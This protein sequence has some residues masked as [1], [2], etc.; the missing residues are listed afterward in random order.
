MNALAQPDMVKPLERTQRTSN[1]TDDE[2]FAL[3]REMWRSG[4]MP[5]RGR[6]KKGSSQPRWA[7]FGFT[8][9]RVHEWRRMAEIP[10][11]QFEA[12]LSGRRQ[13]GKG[14]TRRGILVQF[15]KIN[16]RTADVFEGTPIGDLAEALLR[17]AEAVF[18]ELNKRERYAL[19]HALRFRLR[20]IAGAADLERDE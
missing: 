15:G 10:E 17:G 7:D 19:L 11:D 8:R 13:D 1:L 18:S 9:Q 16:I 12:Y 5:R 14:I 6:P 2:R 4:N 3:L 20:C